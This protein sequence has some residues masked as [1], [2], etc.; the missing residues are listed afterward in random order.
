MLQH[1]VSPSLARIGCP[2]AGPCA[3]HSARGRRSRPRAGSAAHPGR[4]FEQA[5]GIHADATY[6]ASAMLTTQ[7]QN[8]AP[9]DLFLVRGSELS[10]A[11]DRCRP[12]RCGGSAECV[13]ADHLRQRHAG[14]VGAQ[15]L[16]ICRRRRSICCAIP[17]L[18]RLAIANP[19]RAPLRQRRRGRTDQPATLRCAEATAGDRGE[20]CADCAVC[21]LRQC[22]CRTDLA[23]SA[24]T[25]KLSSSG[26]YFVIPRDL[27][28]PIE[29]GAV[30]V[31]KTT[32]A[33]RRAQAARLSAFGAGA[34]ELA[35]AV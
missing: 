32:A 12:G 19:D 24:L 7:I 34:G 14:A 29:Q 10:E 1:P 35:K 33:R 17:T 23:D 26:T 15:G 13:D 5:T 31:S 3:D 8:G 18:K 11:A 6:Q 22:G 2:G 20:H 9:F 28:P 21:R 27:Y 4:S 16:R 25:P 30:I